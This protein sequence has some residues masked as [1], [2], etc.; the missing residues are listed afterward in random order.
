[1]LQKRAAALGGMILLLLLGLIA[2]LAVLIFGRGAQL[3]AAACEQRLRSLPYH[4][5]ARGDILDRC[6]RPLV[7]VEESCLV[8]LPAMI[9][10]QE[11]RIAEL[12]RDLPG[13]D[14]RELAERLR[15]AGNSSF[16]PVV[17]MT[18]L[19][20]AQKEAM[21]RADIPGVL[22]LSLAARY[23][24]QH[25]ASQLIGSVQAGA[26]DG[27]YRG[28]SGLERQYDA[29]L[30]GRED[31]QIRLQVDAEGRVN[32][33]PELYRPDE[34]CAPALCL[35]LDKDYQQIAEQALA[36]AGLAGSCVV[37]DPY[38]GDILAL[39]SWPGFDPYGWQE[40]RPGAYMQRALLLYP[41][42][43]T[44]KTVLAAAALAE[45]VR[46]GSV[47]ADSANEQAK[48]DDGQTAQ[49]KDEAPASFVCRGSYTLPDGR[50][51][52]CAGG[53]A[54]GEVDLARALALSCNCYFVAL[55]QTL[56]G[57]RVLD[58]SRRLGLEQMTVIG[59]DAGSGD[60]VFFD[61]DPE[62]A[63]ELANVCLGED[64]VSLSPLQEAVLFSAFVN[65]GYLVR[66]RLVTATDDGKGG[67]KEYPALKPCR[68]LSPAD[69]ETMRLMLGLVVEEGTGRSAGS[70]I[71]SSGGKTG[72]SE[73]GV[74][75]F[76][77]FF[78]AD[79][80]RL[81]VA[82]CLEQGSSGGAE[83]AAV[84]RSVAEAI[85]VLDGRI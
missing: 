73:T 46:P 75:W 1:M 12:L 66:P 85:T 69:A 54:H 19:A 72:S 76:S 14:R 11:E 68:V 74:V 34:V 4:Q 6:G 82:V 21:D 36:D 56:G 41:P 50:T 53:V 15:T 32:G 61:F 60:A 28:V 25:T 47:G 22:T 9:K 58:Y 77:G 26:D 42:A 64:G 35:T 29:L 71:V 49:S 83:A 33:A 52:S 55:G 63:G 78:P 16:Q 43:S 2:A 62:Q 84:F 37:M 39:A 17:L 20:A 81:V 48:E 10:G 44:F 8:V 80:P 57:E 7:N 65:G 30:S 51:V 70:D 45:G 31:T 24:R 27:V 59:L 18:G 13:V 5:Y 23:D 67:R 3:S 40:A 79:R 38:S